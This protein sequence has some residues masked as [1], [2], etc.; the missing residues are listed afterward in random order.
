MYLAIIVY[1]VLLN[2]P[3]FTVNWTQKYDGKSLFT[4]VID[5]GFKKTAKVSDVW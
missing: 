3:I 4:K 5:K 2:L 1:Q